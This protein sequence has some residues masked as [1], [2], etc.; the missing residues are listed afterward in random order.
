MSGND[1]CTVQGVC[2]EFVIGDLE[3]E[4]GRIPLGM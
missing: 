3:R 4:C 2:V 1:V